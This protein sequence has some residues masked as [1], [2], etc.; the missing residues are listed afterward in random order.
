MNCHIRLV[1]LREAV[2]QCDFARNALLGVNNVLPR[3]R[4][5]AMAG[6]MEKSK[7]LHQEVFR[8]IH[9][10]LTHASN[11]SRMFWPAMPARRKSEDAAA[12]EARCN[13]NPRLARAKTLRECAG[14][15]EEHGLR[16]R[17][18]RDHLEHFDERL[19]D[20]QATSTGHNY[21][22]DFIGP[23]GA[24]AG[25]DEADMM[26][27][28]DPTTNRFRFRGNEYDLQSLA[29]SLGELRAKCEAAITRQEEEVRAT[30][31]RTRGL[32]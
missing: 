28:F 1:Y 18:L 3:I 24:F 20:W 32:T 10:L 17:E 26:R 12:Y 7:I 16:S 19:D 29:D 21:V 23:A 27:W 11:V 14:I 5:A 13:A 15:P 25:I 8:S 22:Q 6:D 2:T 31:R 4:P 30:A 9:S